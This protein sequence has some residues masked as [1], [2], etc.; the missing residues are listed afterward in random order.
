MGD[1]FETERLIL[2]L[3]VIFYTAEIGKIGKAVKRRKNAAHGASR[4]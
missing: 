1:P 2:G 4:G 3:N